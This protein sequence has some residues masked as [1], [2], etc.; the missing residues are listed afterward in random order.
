MLNSDE[1]RNSL[2]FMNK[3]L[4]ATNPNLSST[5]IFSS[6]AE[7]QRAVE[8][9]RYTAGPHDLRFPD[10]FRHGIRFG[11]EPSQRDIYRTILVSNI[12]ADVD[13]T[14]L[15]DQVRGGIV[16]NASLLDTVSITGSKTALIVFV[17]EHEALAVE[18][19][20]SVHRITF[21]SRLARVKIVN[22]PTWPTAMHL[23]K[24]IEDHHHTRCLEVH[25]FPRSVSRAALRRDL[26]MCEA[27]TCDAIEYMEIRSDGV[28]EIRFL[29][30]CQAGRAFGIFTSFRRYR[31]CSTYFT[32]DPCARPPQVMN[33]DKKCEG[34]IQLK[35]GSDTDRHEEAVIGLIVD[36]TVTEEVGRLIVTDCDDGICQ[37]SRPMPRGRGFHSAV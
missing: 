3:K 17:H 5:V 23:R 37:H 28:L 24:A 35:D 14:A 36:S 30:T 10:L 1:N 8:L 21:G 13:I 6:Q 34:E 26:R 7:R 29:S 11:P 32:P 22:T 16:I 25:D 2:D 33:N 18:E 31:Q 9:N 4:Y 12:P 15:L 27:V 19:H 20:A